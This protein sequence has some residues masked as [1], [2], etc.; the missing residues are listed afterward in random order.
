MKKSKRTVLKI[1]IASVIALAICLALYILL[2]L[3]VFVGTVYFG[4]DTQEMRARLLYHTDHQALLDACREISR[5]VV[6]GDLRPGTYNIRVDPDPEASS[7]PQ[8]ILD[9]APNYVY[10]DEGYSGRVMLE[11]HGG[12][13][14]LGV[15]AYPEDYKSPSYSK[16]GDKELIDGLWYYDDGYR[17]NPQWE[18]KTEALIQ[19]GQARQVQ[20]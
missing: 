18:K 2:N 10:V 11:M 14:H 7:F 6:I 4:P 19:K 17:K 9:L 16:F 15:Q 1:F 5:R 13:G 3:Y 20:Q 8:V 12:L